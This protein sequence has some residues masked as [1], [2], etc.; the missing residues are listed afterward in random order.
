MKKSGT[1]AVTSAKGR[2]ALSRFAPQTSSWNVSAWTCADRNA[3]GDQR[4]KGRMMATATP[5]EIAAYRRHG[6]P[7]TARWRRTSGHSRTAN[8]L[9]AS[10]QPSATATVNV[11]L[12][13]TSS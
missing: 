7:A 3:P 2:M 9:N 5:P 4:K 8:C 1:S 11:V 13:G 12:I 10:A 6:A